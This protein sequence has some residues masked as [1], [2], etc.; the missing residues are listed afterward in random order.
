MLKKIVSGGQTGVDRGALDGALELDF[1][2][3]GWCPK[4]RKAEDGIIDL[5][6]PLT[7]H[8]SSNY[9]DRTKANV[10]DSD[11]TLIIYFSKLSGGT[12]ATYEFAKEFAK[13]HTCIDAD[14][15]NVEDAS[16]KVKAFIEENKIEVL[17]VAGPRASNNKD[18][19]PYAKSLVKHLI[20]NICG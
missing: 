12:L 4:G 14:E 16:I 13:P 1:E 19:Y 17:N 5:S 2:V 15:L 20:K 6:Y 3:G 10:I 11:G 9:I 7:E 8:K 18:A